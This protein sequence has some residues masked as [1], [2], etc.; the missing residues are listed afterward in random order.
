MRV[1]YRADFRPELRYNASRVLYEKVQ[2][3]NFWFKISLISRPISAYFS[4]QKYIPT[5]KGVWNGYGMAMEW[6]WKWKTHKLDT[7]NPRKIHETVYTHSSLVYLTS[8]VFCIE[9]SSNHRGRKWLGV[10]KNKLTNY[11]P[12][13]H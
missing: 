2:C 6:L 9:G 3:P 4:A 5:K 13:R 7:E 12:S 1:C 11:R 8:Y 10:L